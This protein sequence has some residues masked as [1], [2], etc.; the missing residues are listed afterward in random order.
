MAEL[1]RLWSDL[2][3]C[4][5]LELAHAECIVSAKQWIERRRVIQLLKGLNP[6]FEGRRANL[7][8]QPKLPS[9]GEVIAA[10]AQ[11]EMRLKLGK[12]GEPVSNPAF[13]MT[14]R[15][16]TRDCYNCGK[17]GHLSYDCTAPRRG[18]GRG[19]NRGFYRGG[20]GRGGHNNSVPPRAHVAVP[21]DGQQSAAANEENKKGGQED[22]TFGSFAHFAHA[23]EGNIEKASIATHK[24]YPE[25][26]LDSGASK[27][28]T[29]NTREF[30]SYD[31][32]PIS[33]IETIQTADGTAQP[34]KGVGTVQCTPFIKLSSVLHVPA[35]PVNLI[36]LSALI[37]QLDCIIYLDKKICVIQERLTGR[38]IGTGT[39]H[40]GLWYMDRGGSVFAFVADERENMAMI[41]HCRMGIM[42]FDKMIRVFPD[43]MRGVDKNK[44][45]CDACEYA[46]H[47]KTIYVSKGIRSI[48]PFMLIHSDVWTC[49]VVS[50]SGMKYLVT[51]IDCHTRMTWAYLMQHKD[52]VFKCFQNFYSYVK[53]QFNVQVQMLRTDNGI[54]YIN[55]GFSN[56]LSEHGILHQT[57][58]PDTPPQNGVAERKN[59]HILEVARSL[60]FTMNVPK[61]LWSEA[62]MTAT[63]LI[64]R[65][66]SRVM[67]MKSPCE[68]LMGEN[69]FLVPPKVFGCTCF[70]RDHRPSVGK[71]DPR[72]VKC[73]FIGYASGKR[74][75]KCWSPS[76]RRTF[77]SMDV[78]FRE[79]EPFYGEKTDLS[80][81][82]EELDQQ[83]N[84]EVGQEGEK[85]ILASPDQHTQQPFVA[86]IPIPIAAAPSNVVPTNVHAELPVVQ[87][88][89][90]QMWPRLN[91]RD[92]MLVYL[93]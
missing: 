6:S 54:E 30:E 47:T 25:W 14:E 19:Y 88:E 57:S 18:R 91:G 69:T 2:D 56:F 63:Y 7:F 75:Y 61:F 83:K 44:L 58:C 21:K 29:S 53:T 77:V 45:K 51:F 65:M 35:F 9:I 10:M 8:H 5:P 81:L 31:K 38:R 87:P 1:Q 11:E 34:I 73:I 79:S 93:R 20:R 76:E 43:V 60:M 80:M 23:N 66:P 15:Q 16:E 37:D 33:Q 48:F 74:G 86:S 28:V 62:V 17:P 3:D 22:A 59:R 39:R 92:N 49:P 24:I 71:L 72:A 27:H 52:E 89:T 84:I 90:V 78:T 32:Y 46:K 85:S 41:H 68:M 4:D 67:G 26:I 42:S 12:G 13:F 50:V 70:V 55:K 40:R 82:F 64:N 36:S